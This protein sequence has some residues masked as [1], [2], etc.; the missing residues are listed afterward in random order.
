MLREAEVMEDFSG[1]IFVGRLPERARLRKQIER[2]RGGRGAAV[3]VAGEAGLGKTRLVGDL[4][5]HAKSEGVAVAWAEALEYA[6]APYATLREVLRA[7]D[8]RAP[9]VLKRF[10][11][12]REALASVEALGEGLSQADEPQVARRRTL[13]A[14][15]TA[16]EAHAAATPVTLVVEDVQWIDAASADALLHIAS[17]IDERRILMVLTLRDDADVAPS[18]HAWLAQLQRRGMQRIPLTPLSQEETSE[19]ID[20]CHAGMIAVTIKRSIIE[21]SGGNPLFVHALLEHLADGEPGLPTSLAASVQSKLAAFAPEQRS[22]LRAAALTTHFDEALL[23]GLLETSRT[24]VRDALRLG[25]DRGILGAREDGKF[26]FRHALI[27]RVVAEELLPDERAELHARMVL[28]LEAAAKPDPLQLAFHLRGAGDWL[29]A[30]FFDE[31]NGDDAMAAS[32][33]VDAARAY[34]RALTHRPFDDASLPLRRKYIE[35]CDL[36][37]LRDDRAREIETLQAWCEAQERWVEAT[38]FAVELARARFGIADDEGAIQAAQHAVD[39]AQTAEVPPALTFDA[40]ALTGWLYAH[41]R[42]LDEARKA[43]AQAGE[44]LDHA[45]P[46]GRCWYYEA[47]AAEDVHSGRCERWQEWC[48]AMIAASQEL[49]PMARGN[50]ILSAAA[51]ALSSRIEDFAY[52]KVCIDRSTAC[53]DAAGGEGVGQALALGAILAYLF[54]DLPLARRYVERALATGDDDSGAAIVIARVGI[55][56]GLRLDDDIL[57]RRSLRKDI[58]D[59]AFATN[60]AS[61]LGPISAATAEYLALRNRR[62]EAQGLVEHTIARLTDAAQNGDLLVLAARLGSEKST[63]VRARELLVD[64]A[65]QSATL[66]AALALFDAW[67]ASGEKRR[68][69]AQDA[70][71][72]YA[73]LGWLLHEAQSHEVAGELAQAER[74]Y[75]RCGA[76]ADAHRLDL[77]QHERVGVGNL[78]SRES[79]VARLIAQGKSNRAIA[80]A[81]VLSAKTVEHHIASIFS[82]LG[83]RSRTEVAGIVTGERQALSDKLSITSRLLHH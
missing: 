65:P 74:L 68:R 3:L 54:G 24:G 1:G 67:S 50:R 77:E 49:A 39:L 15:L 10:P 13:D 51:L 12:L 53:F 29:R 56:L 62:D 4:A 38:E 70:A 11:A 2:L 81:L 21:L 26:A 60:S 7:L 72:Q 46:R 43:L 61:T 17:L 25:R 36:G 71:R 20:V 16:I 69:C 76:T 42:L 59:R 19:L 75:E 64:L 66:R 30:A 78:T 35:S 14:I 18:V 45:Q 48:E 47:L 23:C 34:A 73:E 63:R 80:Q 83:A 57:A 55:L 31:R 27:K 52:A 9:K 22:V 41:G 44:W 6:S 32:A 58:L 40:Y 79:E 8:A 82:K 5:A 28:A 37:A 33:F